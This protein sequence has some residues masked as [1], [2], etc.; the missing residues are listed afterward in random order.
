MGLISAWMPS[1]E[2]GRRREI[3][4][5]RPRAVLGRPGPGDAT[6][7]VVAA[8]QQTDEGFRRVS[9][10]T[11]VGNVAGRVVVN[12]DADPDDDPDAA[13]GGLVVISGRTEADIRR[14]LRR[15]IDTH[16]YLAS[17][18]VT[19]VTPARGRRTPRS[20]RARSAG[21]GAS[22][23][24]GA[25]TQPRPPAPPGL[26]P[27]PGDP[28]FL[29][30]GLLSCP[31]RVPVGI[32]F[33]LTVG[34]SLE[35]DDAELNE[36]FRLTPC[37]VTVDVE[38]PEGCTLR[39]DE[40]W[41]VTLDVQDPEHLPSVVLHVT[42]P[43]T[44]RRRPSTRTFLA[45]YSVPGRTLGYAERSFALAG[46]TTRLGP[47]ARSESTRSVA[48]PDGPRNDL[49]IQ[50]LH[51]PD[52]AASTLRW[53]FSSRHAHI[54]P[55]PTALKTYVDAT[56]REFVTGMLALIHGKTGTPDLTETLIGYCRAIAA[57]IPDEVITALHEAARI[58]AE[59]GTTA[60]VLLHAAEAYIPWELAYTETPLARAM[61]AAPVP[62]I[63]GAQVTMG[64]W[65]VPR[66]SR[67]STPPS[68]ALAVGSLAVV[69]GR[70]R[71]R[72]RLRGA[73]AEAR[74]LVAAY[75]AHAVDATLEDIRRC[76]R[77]DPDAQV[78][79]FA[80]HGRYAPDEPT[81]DGLRMP[82]GEVLSPV[83]VSGYTFDER[84]SPHP[85]VFVNACEAGNAT[86]LLGTAVGLGPA[87]LQAGATACVA[88][89]WTVGDVPARDLALRF[90][91]AVLGHG[92]AP[93]EAVRLE[94]AAVDLAADQPDLTPLAYQFFGSPH[95][96]VA[97]AVSAG[98]PEAGQAAPT[99]G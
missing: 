48:S 96:R 22:G 20:A 76:L 87:F 1:P 66:G 4:V 10:T 86:S 65:V 58:A 98:S 18:H 54:T 33:E 90:Y 70:Y 8:F 89:L 64:R 2:P 12:L 11:R 67:P 56:P 97:P 68:D 44:A 45:V 50:V 17:P 39:G 92:V 35:T 73:E 41:R 32:E 15:L 75:G 34:L 43:P 25:T 36:P 51:H 99:A 49:E 47:P 27:Q 23:A 30:Y 81:S 78:I 9:P 38:A 63:L 40:A 71:G 42:V 6:D 19:T 94:R 52:D 72:A 46:P 26:G 69:N 91:D 28:G 85:L 57:A 16:G 60:R 21:M 55:S 80:L 95:L 88:P 62:P 84:T 31:D 13:T 83:A 24:S 79:H 61:P 37:V 93:A 3:R 5:G 29:A 7:L 77:G 53:H 14:R 59:S 82:D 74:D